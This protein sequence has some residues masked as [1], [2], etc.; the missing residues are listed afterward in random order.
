MLLQVTPIAT[1]A[2]YQPREP[3][4]EKWYGLVGSPDGKALYAAPYNAPSVLVIDAA[5]KTASGIDSTAVHTSEISAH[6]YCGSTLERSEK[7]CSSLICRAL[8]GAA[9]P[10]GKVGNLKS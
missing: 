10:P 1:G 4:G 5:R 8:A 6:H 9:W 3:G 2:A 7:C